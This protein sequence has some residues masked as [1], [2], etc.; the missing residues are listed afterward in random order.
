MPGWLVPNN[1]GSDASH[2]DAKRN[3]GRAESHK[4]CKCPAV[5]MT[6]VSAPNE[7]NDHQYRYYHY[8]KQENNHR[9]FHPS[10][11]RLAHPSRVY[12]TQYH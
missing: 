8:H 12:R 2:G 10:S 1:V 11:W 5:N 7:T 6:L 4:R 9:G 3:D